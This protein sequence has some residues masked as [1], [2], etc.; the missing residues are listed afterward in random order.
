MNACL[1]TAL[2]DGAQKPRLPTACLLCAAARACACPAA[3]KSSACRTG[4]LLPGRRRAKA[5]PAGLVDCCLAG[6]ARRAKASPAGSRFAS[7]ARKSRVCRVCC[8]T[9]ITGHW[10]TPA[11]LPA[12]FAWRRAKAAPA[13]RT[14]QLL[15]CLFAGLGRGAQ[16]QRLVNCPPA[17]LHSLLACLVACGAQ[18]QRPPAR[19]LNN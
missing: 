10:S 15:D 9:G 17:S 8:R 5:A 11:C 19:L 13:R 6:G 2:P 16:K 12:C 7:A 1:H 18:K 14:G 3:R 4:G